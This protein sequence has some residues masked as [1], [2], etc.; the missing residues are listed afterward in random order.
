M[1]NSQRGFI[2]P[3]LIIII[4][5]LVIGGGV[6]IY[7]QNKSQQLN[8]NTQTVSTSTAK[9]TSSTQV[10]INQDTT[11][12][13]PI[14][15]LGM[16][17]Y[18][19]SSFGFSFWYPSSWIIKPTSSQPYIALRGG[20]IV[21]TVVIGPVNDSSNSIEIQEFTSFARSITDNSSAGPA[22]NGSLSLTYFFDP[23]THTW[24]ARDIDGSGATTTIA[25][26]VS[27]NTMG[28][29]HL[30]HGNARFGDDYIV[31]LSAR[32]FLVISS[33]EVGTI[34]E[35]SLAQTI[36]ATDPSVAIPLNIAGQ[37]K[38]IQAEA[39]AYGVQ[40]S[41]D[42]ITKPIIMSAS[43]TWSTVGP[44]LIITGSGFTLHGNDI[45]NVDDGSVTPQV[46]STNNGTEITNILPLAS[47]KSYL[48]GTQ[49]TISVTNKNGTS[50]TFM[51]TI[52]E[53]PKNTDPRYPL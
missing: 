28:G 27:I 19:D 34:Q 13:N 15:V 29:L 46:P 33:V 37:I 14:S 35:G 48:P 24:M 7:T 49:H 1:K 44:L 20:T 45:N 12:K 26:N 18:T 8:I 30:L 25:A 38:T 3:L 9:T 17:K 21:K 50:N 39:T 16:T 40:T 42:T 11:S 41:V 47:G 51:V 32:N 22:G 10:T 2:I 4:A 36:V 6:Y 31:P 53:G 5:V 23:S 43:A 52:K